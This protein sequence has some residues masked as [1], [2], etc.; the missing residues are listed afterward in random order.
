MIGNINPTFIGNLTRLRQ[1]HN[2][3]FDIAEKHFPI[4]C[5]NGYKIGSGISV[6]PACQSCGGYPVFALVFGV[7]KLFFWVV[8]LSP[9]AVVL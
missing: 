5:T 2:T 8:V 7:H 3:I 4:R 1:M 6:I 9:T